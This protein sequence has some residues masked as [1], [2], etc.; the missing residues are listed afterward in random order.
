MDKTKRLNISC[1]PLQHNA[2]LRLRGLKAA[3]RWIR[4]RWFCWWVVI[5]CT[6]SSYETSATPD[7][8]LEFSRLNR[9]SPW[10]PSSV[11]ESCKG[12]F[13]LVPG[14]ILVPGQC[15]WLEF[16]DW[17]HLYSSCSKETESSCLSHWGWT[18]LLCFCVFPPPDL[19]HPLFI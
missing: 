6:D 16:D 15:R 9:N 19:Q 1:F 14:R 2:L 4:H 18:T 11:P 17:L 8:K 13:F 12:F 5:I 3:C 7:V 10:S